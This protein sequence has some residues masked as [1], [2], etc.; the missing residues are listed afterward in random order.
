M[1]YS[2]PTLERHH[3]NLLYDFYGALLTEHQRT[4]FSLYHADDNSLSEIAEELNI[5]PQAVSDM[6]KRTTKKLERYEE[7]LGLVQRSMISA[8]TVNE[9]R[10]LI[11]TV[12]GPVRL[13]LSQ[14]LD[15][16]VKM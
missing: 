6:L 3:K 15:A 13:Q 7:K 11:D 10:R 1:P 4:C 16:L 14:T 9:M 2:D 12:P 8:D 5:T